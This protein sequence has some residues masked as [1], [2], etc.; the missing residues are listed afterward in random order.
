MLSIPETEPF[1]RERRGDDRLTRRQ[2]LENLD[3]HATAEPNGG[4]NDRG[5]VEVRENIGDVAVNA[6]ALPYEGKHGVGRL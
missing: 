5:G 4:G 6:D 1:E 3:A 2:R